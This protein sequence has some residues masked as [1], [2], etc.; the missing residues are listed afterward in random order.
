M[1]FKK[2]E[3]KAF[4]SFHFE[5]RGGPTVFADGIR[6]LTQE[7]LNS[8]DARVAGVA[9]LKHETATMLRGFRHEMR[10][11]H[12]ELRRK[13]ADLRRFLRNAESS[14]L[15]HFRALHQS[16]RA[17]QEARSQHLGAMQAGFR[18]MLFGFHQD[19]QAAAGHWRSMA[20]ALAK[21]RASFAR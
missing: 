11:V 13:A 9:T 2:R 16:I 17:G 1:A 14:R 19:H 8:F 4:E 3:K 6:H 21:K 20:A 7:I 15:R 10:N 12:H 18:Q 5:E